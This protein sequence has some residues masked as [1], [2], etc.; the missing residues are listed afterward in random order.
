LQAKNNG[1]EEMNAKIVVIVISVAG[2]VL[3]SFGIIQDIIRQRK[4]QKKEV[5]K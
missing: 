5:K 1:S 3:C 2:M 4:E